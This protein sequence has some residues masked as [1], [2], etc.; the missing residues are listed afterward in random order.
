MAFSTGSLTLYLFSCTRVA[1]SWRDFLC[2]FCHN[3]QHSNIATLCTNLT[4]RTTVLARWEQMIATV[5]SQSLRANGSRDFLLFLECA[6][7]TFGR[8][9]GQRLH[10]NE[11]APLQ[12]QC[13]GTRAHERSGTPDSNGCP[14]RRMRRSA[15]QW[16]QSP[17]FS[18]ISEV[19]GVTC[20]DDRTEGRDEQPTGTSLVDED[21]H[22]EQPTGTSLVDEDWHVVCV[23][24][25]IWTSSMRSG[26]TGKF[27]LMNSGKHVKIKSG[28]WW[29][30]WS[31]L[32]L[33]CIRS[34]S[35]LN[36]PYHWKSSLDDTVVRQ[37]S[38]II[39][40]RFSWSH[41]HVPLLKTIWAKMKR[42]YQK[43]F[44]PPRSRRTVST[45]WR[46]T[47]WDITKGKD[48]KFYFFPELI[49]IK[50]DTYYSDS[51]YDAWHPSWHRVEN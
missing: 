22:D 49:H 27:V 11:S 15:G 43:A 35:N 25:V 2:G 7:Q 33:R 21:W 50:R 51:R 44:R 40:T 45:N 42:E 9:M 24:I 34:S 5:F 23:N 26:M 20:S 16:Q 32:L 39:V 1:R 31:S 17:F 8:W 12:S 6:F 18:E 10:N 46:R 29:T 3:Q 36:C 41:H 38:N 4:G 47:R 13:Y 37:L 14:K 30:L 48:Y 19:Q 28:V